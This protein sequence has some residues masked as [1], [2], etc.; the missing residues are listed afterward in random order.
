MS[1]NKKHDDVKLNESSRKK[2]SSNN[3]PAVCNIL[4]KVASHPAI[5]IIIPNKL[6]VVRSFAISRTT[7]VCVSF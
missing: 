6:N 3:K 4:W 5:N 2:Q 1:S 7:K